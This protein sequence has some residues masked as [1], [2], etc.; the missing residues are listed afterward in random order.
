MAGAATAST[1]SSGQAEE[2]GIDAARVL[3]IL[4]FALT[5]LVYLN[6]LRFQFVYDDLPQIVRNPRVIEAYIGRE[7]DHAPA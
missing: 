1:T 6:T 7:Q 3:L 2:T 5:A 4:A